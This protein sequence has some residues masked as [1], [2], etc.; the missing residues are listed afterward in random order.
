MKPKPEGPLGGVA[1][2]VWCGGSCDSGC[3]TEETCILNLRVS[4]QPGGGF[5]FGLG[6]ARFIG[7]SAQ[8]LGFIV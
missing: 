4:P 7:F 2:S 5:G 6:F 3:F 1:K 8:S